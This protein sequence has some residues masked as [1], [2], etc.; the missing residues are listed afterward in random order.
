ADVAYGAKVTVQK[1][2]GPWVEVT[3]AAGHQGWLHESAL[4]QK[5]LKLVSGSIEAGTGASG[6]E[7]ALAGKGFNET[8]EKEYR[9]QNADL[10]YSWVDRME[11]MVVTAPEMETFLRQGGIQSREGGR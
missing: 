11:K 8:V 4:S 6:E 9:K 3:D 10:D 1:R 5:K 7:V 2:Q